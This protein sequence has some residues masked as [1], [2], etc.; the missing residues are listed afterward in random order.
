MIA[1]ETSGAIIQ[2]INI[3]V[4]NMRLEFLSFNYPQNSKIQ[5]EELSWYEVFCLL[6][7]TSSVQIISRS[8][9]I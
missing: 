6:S 8:V 3:Q 4:W 2:F 9:S 1:G 7:Y 5:N